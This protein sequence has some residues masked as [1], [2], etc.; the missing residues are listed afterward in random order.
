MRGGLLSLRGF[1]P[2]HYYNC[3]LGD[4]GE[5][6]KDAYGEEIS[7]I[8]DD[9]RKEL[10]IANELTLADIYLADEIR[11]GMIGPWVHAGRELLAN[12]SKRLEE[13]A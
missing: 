1:T 10:R 8:L 11:T 5:S 9:I 13:R 12:I 6:M 7:N 2:R 4:K 3:D